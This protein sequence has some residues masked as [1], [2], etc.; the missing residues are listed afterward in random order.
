MQSL[1]IRKLTRLI[2]G[3]LWLSVASIRCIRWIRSHP[4]VTFRYCSRLWTFI[5][6][7]AVA[8]CG[9]VRHRVKRILK[10]ESVAIVLG[11]LLLTGCKPKSTPAVPISSGTIVLLKSGIT[12][13]AFVVTKQSDFPEVVDYTWFLR[14]DGKSTFDAKDPACAT[15]SVSSA[16]SVAFGPFDIQWST[17]G[18]TWGYVYYPSQYRWVKTPWGTY[19]AYRVPWGPRMAVI[20]ERD[21]AKVDA[22]DRR[23]KFQR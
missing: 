8:Y 15:G 2:R 17:G 12:N 9:K 22:K 20:D 13:A 21:L 4:D 3:L 18:G 19:W 10:F 6:E 7:L 14:W 23:W 16:K 11:V 1:G 5:N